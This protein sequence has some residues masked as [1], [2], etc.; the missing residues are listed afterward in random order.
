MNTPLDVH[1]V[2]NIAYKCVNYKVNYR[3]KQNIKYLTA[4]V[5]MMLVVRW[6]S[7]AHNDRLPTSIY[8]IY[9]SMTTTLIVIYV[10]YY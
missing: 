4:V 10:I 5:L 2:Q 7:H 3:F 9:E 1:F 6:K 8:D